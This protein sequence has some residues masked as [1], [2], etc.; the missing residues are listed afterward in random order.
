MPT[1]NWHCAGCKKQLRRTPRPGQ[2]CACG[3]VYV[4]D[5]GLT[6]TTKPPAQTKLRL[7]G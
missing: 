7:P 4:N 2:T 6:V 3:N 5:Q 1:Q